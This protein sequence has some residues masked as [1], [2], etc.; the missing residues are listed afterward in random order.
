[1]A[2]GQPLGDERWAPGMVCLIKVFFIGLRL[3]AMGYQFDQRVYANGVIWGN[4]CFALGAGVWAA[5]VSHTAQHDCMTDPPIKTLDTKAWG[6]LLVGNTWYV[7][8]HS[9]TGR[10]KHIPITLQGGDT[11]KLAPAS[12]GLCPT[13]FFPLLILICI[14]LL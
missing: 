12:P 13:C 1:M 9:A 7:F 14:L 2:F 10:I 4:T 3:W 5:E 8:L 6:S 11:W